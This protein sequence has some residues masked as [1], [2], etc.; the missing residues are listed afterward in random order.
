MIPHFCST[1]VLFQTQALFLGC[2]SFFTKIRI[3]GFPRKVRLTW[4]W[5][6]KPVPKMEP[7]QVETW[8]N[9]CGLP[10]RSFNFEPQPLLVQPPHLKGRSP[11][12][13]NGA[14]S[15]SRPGAPATIPPP[16]NTNVMSTHKTQK[17]KHKPWPTRVFRRK[18]AQKP[19]KGGI[20]SRV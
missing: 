2:W 17:E 11:G 16:P 9:T 10:L 14:D 7:W 13:L 4:L 19:K 6:K 18:T 5:L 20:W 15:I 12:A 1:I 8:T 3:P